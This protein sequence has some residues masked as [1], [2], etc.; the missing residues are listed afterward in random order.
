MKQLHSQHG[1]TKFG[2]IG[3]VLS[4]FV[5]TLGFEMLLRLIPNDANIVVP[6]AI[7]S[8]FILPLTLSVQLVLKLWDLK[9]QDD[10]SRNERRRLKSIINKKLTNFL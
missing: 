4:A 3:V 6:W 2:V 1:W 7:V 8:L 5:G 9:E 10:I